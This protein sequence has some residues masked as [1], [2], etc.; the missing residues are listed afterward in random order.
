[1]PALDFLS[2]RLAALGE[3]QLLREYGAPRAE[4]LIDACSNDYLGLA[5]ADVS[6]ATLLTRDPPGAGA[7][8]LIHGTLP[9]HVELERETADWVRQ[10]ASLLFATGYAANLGALAAL[11]EP[12]DLVISDAL[13]HASLIDGIRLARC[14]PKVIPH[15]DLEAARTALRQ[16]RPGQRCWLVFESYYSIDADRPDLNALHQLAS[17]ADAAL[18]IDEA[19]ALGVFGPGGAGGCA[20]AGV[21]ADVT[22][23][24]LGKGIGVQGAFVAGSADL[25]RWLWNRARSFVFST[26]PSPI[27]T[28]LALNNVR[29]ARAADDLRQRLHERTAALRAALAS[30]GVSVL[31]EGPIVPIVVGDAR[32][33]V[34][35][36]ER[37]GE[38][39]IRVQA[40]RP[41][42]VAQGSARLRLTAHADWSAD[43]VDQVAHAVVD[44]L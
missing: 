6:R 27:V 35:L 12:D 15:L 32:R 25:Q 9:A 42:T 10:P 19:H 38:R 30:A 14:R 21:T 5:T 7:S 24:T 2:I 31:G 11:L 17:E 20:A 34:E 41:P 43:T 28:R 16:R 18:I 37:V 4:Q 44:A 8:R 23:G 36:A 26:A 33:T 1:M 13:N 22:V 3:Q 39:G 29:R 40:I